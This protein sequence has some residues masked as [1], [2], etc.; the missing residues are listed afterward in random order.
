MVALEL[1]RPVGGAPVRTAVRAL[2][3]LVL[4]A[5]CA[6]AEPK[7]VPAKPRKLTAEQRL[8][9][10]AIKAEHESLQLKMAL[11]Q[12]QAA[13]LEKKHRA[14]MESAKVTADDVVNL[15]TGEITKQRSK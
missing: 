10:R 2:L 8:E 6:H 11:L 13:D 14:I 5:A 7:P 1:P 12:Q 9:L 4:L 15:E 3:C